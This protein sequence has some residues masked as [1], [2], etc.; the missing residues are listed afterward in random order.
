M[1][2]L[3]AIRNILKEE[4]ANTNT[5][6]QSIQST[7]DGK[8]TGV[9]ND[10]EAQKERISKLESYSASDN[11]RIE[12][13]AIQ[14]EVLKQ[15]RLRNNI[16]LT[17]LPPHAFEHAIKTTNK[18]ME[19]LRLDLLPSDYF[20]YADR[21]KSSIIIQ[22]DNYAHKRYFMDTL[23]ARNELL[24]EEILPSIQSNSKLY[25]NDQLTPYFANIF[26]KAWTAKKNKQLHSA[27][28]LGGRIK[29]RKTVNSMYQLIESETQLIDIIDIDAPAEVLPDNANGSP[30]SSSSNQ[31]KTESNE[32]QKKQVDLTRNPF[33]HSTTA[34]TD[35]RRNTHRTAPLADRRNANQTQQWQRMRSKLNHHHEQSRNGQRSRQQDLGRQ[36]ELSPNKY[37]FPSKPKQQQHNRS[38]HIRNQN[39]NYSYRQIDEAHY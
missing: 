12:T 33:T 39:R 20:A 3:D 10:V 11:R 38:Q 15:D 25:C 17:G 28:S 7:I 27:S 1:S 4:L 18:I 24:V 29:V 5:K 23:R 19:V 37:H 31:E 22:F 21:N 35:Y 8:I 36:I 34:S 32:E 30:N 16:R 9:I 2:E 13:I 26:Q 14:L 6:L